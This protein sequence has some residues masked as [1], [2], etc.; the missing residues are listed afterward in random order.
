MAAI[1]PSSTALAAFVRVRGLL[2]KLGAYRR[3]VKLYR[4]YLA[5]RGAAIGA[6]IN[7]RCAHAIP[8]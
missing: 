5:R 2:G 3:A 4:A 6:Y 1:Q 7:L 8:P